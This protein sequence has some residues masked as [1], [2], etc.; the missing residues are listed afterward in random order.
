MMRW[1]TWRLECSVSKQD[2]GQT[3]YS[4]RVATSQGKR[5]PRFDPASSFQLYFAAIHRN[6]ATALHRLGCN[7]RARGLNSANRVPEASRLINM[8]EFSSP[9][10]SSKRR[11]TGRFFS[12][13]SRI[14]LTMVVVLGLLAGAVFF[15]FAVLVIAEGKF[16]QFSIAV[17]GGVVSWIVAWLFGKAVTSIKRKMC[18]RAVA[19]HAD[20][21]RADPL[22]AIGHNNHGVLCHQKGEFAKAIAHFDAAIRFDPSFP[23]AYVGRVNAFGALGQWDRVIAEYT[24]V[25]QQDPK[26]ALAY[27][28]RATAYN[29]VGR[30]ERSIPDATAAIQLTGALYLAYAARGFGY[31]Q[32]G[33][34]NGGIKFIAIVWM[35]AT[36]AFLRRDH[37]DWRT[38]TGSRADFENAIADFTAALA[39]NPQ[40]WDCHFGRARAYR[41][42]GLQEKA[43]ADE[44]M[45]GRNLR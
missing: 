15:V 27:C 32:R 23:N 26:N 7:S 41:A 1:I 34:F 10:E 8:V 45:G 44:S 14:V 28:A 13:V 35:L 5:M 17:G 36:F 11:R 19:E 33:G 39:L 24:E 40:A 31:L 29:G 20:A 37:F 30:W 16:A 38:P 22:N 6:L 21:I 43:A 2:D 25:I 18:D 3:Q 12:N 42:L 9:S 4:S